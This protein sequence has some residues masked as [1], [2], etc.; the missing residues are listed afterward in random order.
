MLEAD[1]FDLHCLQTLTGT[2]FV[3]TTYPQAKDVDTVLRN[4]YVDIIHT[5]LWLPSC[6]TYVSDFECMQI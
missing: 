1:A 2:K 6:L 4:M 5:C 3:V